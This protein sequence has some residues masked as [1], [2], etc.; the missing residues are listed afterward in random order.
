MRFAVVDVIVSC[1]SGMLCTKTVSLFKGLAE[2]YRLVDNRNIK[3]AKQGS[4]LNVDL[5]E[6]NILYNKVLFDLYR[7]HAN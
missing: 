2:T 3:S 4:I 1:C 7:V 5:K 6:V